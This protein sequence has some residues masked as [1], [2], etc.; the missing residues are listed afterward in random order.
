MGLVFWRTG[1]PTG[2]AE[3]MNGIEILTKEVEL[4]TERVKY[5]EEKQDPTILALLA[6][7]TELGMCPK[8][9]AFNS[10]TYTENYASSGS[11]STII[12]RVY[13]Y[14]FTY[15]NS[16]Q[17]VEFRSPY[18]SYLELQAEVSRRKAA[19][20]DACKAEG[21]CDRKKRK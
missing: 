7:A 9:E 4:L 8:H 3:T 19:K 2:W 18:K 6:E 12:G 10:Y 17:P 5:L 11:S 20:Y 21:K 16:L 1:G 15:S 14:A 13:S